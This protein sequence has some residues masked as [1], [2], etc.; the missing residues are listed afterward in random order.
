MIPFAI[1][2][3][4]IAVVGA[5]Y[6]ASPLAKSATTPWARLGGLGL[7]AL[8]ALASL[9]LYA[10]NAHPSLPGLPHKARMAELAME[11][12]EALN[13]TEQIE[14]VRHHLRTDGPSAEGY[15][16]LGRLLARREPNLEAV[17]AFQNALRLEIDPL[18]LSDLGQTLVNM[19]EGEVTAEARRVF[20]EAHDLNRDLPEPAFFLGLGTY[21]DGDRDGAYAQWVEIID[22]LSRDDPFRMAIIARA[23]DLLSRPNAGP[24]EGEAGAAPFLQ[25][26]G[27]PDAMIAG[28][29]ARLRARVEA[30][31]SVLGDWLILI[32]AEATRGNRDR[33]QADL[34]MARTQFSNDEHA[35]LFLFALERAL[36][37]QSEGVN[38]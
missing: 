3:A 9:G 24:I 1:L 35:G 19:N 16:L 20:N 14:L 2:S 30:D 26:G 25:A 10:L 22:R 36:S 6:I 34:A 21:Q 27:D 12:P 28:M 4:L 7:A 5:F 8:I 11:N 17:A 38:P 33:A 29:I 31:P 15:T 18:V 13:L 23:V 37:L 32:R